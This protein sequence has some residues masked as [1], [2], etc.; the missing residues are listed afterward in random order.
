LAEARLAAW[1]EDASLPAEQLL[2]NNMEPPAFAK[3]LALPVL[4]GQLENRFGLKPRMSGSG[5]ACFALLRD[6][7]DT[8]PIVAAIRQAWGQSAFVADTRLT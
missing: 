2:F 3:F 8:T 1:L 7:A 5:S 4:C 6:D